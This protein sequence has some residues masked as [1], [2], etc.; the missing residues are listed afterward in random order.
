MGRRKVSDTESVRQGNWSTIS[1]FRVPLGR[2]LSD[3]IRVDHF[4]G[5]SLSKIKC[6][7]ILLL[8][9]SL[10]LKPA[11]FNFGCQRVNEM[12]SCVSDEKWSRNAENAECGFW[13][14]LKKK[15]WKAWKPQH[16]PWTFH[17]GQLE[18]GNSHLVAPPLGITETVSCSINY[19]YKKCYS[20]HLSIE[21][22]LD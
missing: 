10:W 13:A 2:V 3:N 12:K 22:F 11:K 7:V 15:R 5:R 8:K 19:L 20:S 6:Q 17:L 1:A 9:R 14:Q 4:P 21:S 16:T 18:P